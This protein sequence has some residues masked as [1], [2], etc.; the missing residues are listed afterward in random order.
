MGI[1]ASINRFLDSADRVVISFIA[2]LLV[3]VIGL[4]FADVMDRILFAKNILF[5]QQVEIWLMCLVV[6]ISA[7]TLLR[8]GRHITVD[9]IANKVTGLPK[10]ILILL[11]CLAAAFFGFLVMLSGI[12]YTLFLAKT[13]VTRLVGVLVPFAPLFFIMVPLGISLLGIYGIS[14]IVETIIADYGKK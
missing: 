5:A 10:R 12:E 13:E 4:V 7:G 9:F 2:I 14:L 8:Q 6:F 3:A 11:H 1:W